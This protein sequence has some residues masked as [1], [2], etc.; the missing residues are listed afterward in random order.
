MKKRFW[1]VSMA[2]VAVFCTV[3][4]SAC[5]GPSVEDLIRDDIIAGMDAI[6]PDSEEF[7]EGLEQG[8][9]GSFETLGIDSTEFAEAYLDGYSYEIGD[10]NVDKDAGKATAEVTVRMKSLTEIMG[11]FATS[12]QEWIEGVDP[13]TLSGEEDLYLKGGEILMQATKDAEAKESTITFAYTRDDDDQ[14]SWSIDDDAA[15]V[16]LGAME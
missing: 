15:S 8:A 4:L 9:D 6:S 13:S 1:A 10:I 12:F 7:M 3:L 11:N 16:L 2:L 5:G 14:N